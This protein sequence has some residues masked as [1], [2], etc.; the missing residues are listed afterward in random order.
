[1]TRAAALSLPPAVNVAI[2]FEWLVGAGGGFVFA[3]IVAK[4]LWDAH[5]ADDKDI[6]DQRDAA[7][8]RL[9]DVIGLVK[10]GQPK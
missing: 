1:M 2:P 5:R 8:R 3:V 10:K 7:V 4:S 6:R 9:E